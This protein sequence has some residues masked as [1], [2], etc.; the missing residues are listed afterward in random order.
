MKRLLTV[1]AGGLLSA[2]TLATAGAAEYPSRTIEWVIPYPPGGGTDI[3]GRVLSDEMGKALGRTIVV[4]NKPGAATAIGASYTARAKPD[5][6]T[7]MSADTATLAAN[8]Y[9]YKKLTYNPETDFDSVGLTVRFPLILVVNP[10]VPANNYAEFIEWVKQQG[11][12]VDYG[13]PGPGSP[14]HLATELFR[15]R[16]GTNLVHVPYKGAA[17]AVQDV[18][19]GQIPMMFVDSATGQQHIAAGTLRPIAVASNARLESFPDVPTLQELGLD[20][21]EAY[22]WQGVVVPKGTPKEIIERL[23]VE[24]VKALNNPEVVERFKSMGL[25]IT[26]STPEEM[27]QYADAQR[28]LWSEVI[29]TSN[30]SLD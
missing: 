22:A 4:A 30:I 25:E 24:L 15:I 1:I 13:T 6:Y 3:V 10:S 11:N 19:G 2:L 16:T 7:V 23:N 12:G 27:D 5:G 26:P 28:K 21:F 9:L 29:R 17:P 8:P 20:G 14:H 18:L